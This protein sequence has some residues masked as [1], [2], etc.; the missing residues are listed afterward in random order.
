VRRPRA[1]LIHYDMLHRGTGRL[2]EVRQYL[3]AFTTLIGFI[4]VMRY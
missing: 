2:V 3:I 1:L 4:T